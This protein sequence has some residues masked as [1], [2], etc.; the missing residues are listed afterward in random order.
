MKIV[1]KIVIMAMCLCLLFSM[2]ACGEHSESVPVS[3]AEPSS[4]VDRGLTAVNLLA[5]KVHCEEYFDLMLANASIKESGLYAKICGGDYTPVQTFEIVL[6]DNMLTVMSL[7]GDEGD[8]IPDYSALPDNIRTEME[9]RFL[10]GFSSRIAS[11]YGM[12]AVVLNS[13]FQGGYSFVD[14]SVEPQNMMY[15]YL[16]ENTY[17]IVCVFT[18]GND[19]IVNVSATILMS[20]ELDCDANGVTED[21]LS[22]MFTRMLGKGMVKS[23]KKVK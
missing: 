10:S 15:L 5:E 4:L 18:F 16:F 23:I 21:D 8:N 1:K 3:K 9:V 22:S 12:D 20:E 14:K 11:N 19:G 17:P 2:V 6:V 7:Q 13:I